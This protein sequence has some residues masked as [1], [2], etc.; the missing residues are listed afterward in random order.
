MLWL[1]AE[2]VGVR[3]GGFDL[4]SLV[5]GNLTE[6]YG[7][8]KEEAARFVT[9][10]Q[11]DGSVRF[12]PEGQEELVY[13]L[14]VDEKGWVAGTSPYET[15]YMLTTDEKTV[16]GILRTAAEQRLLAPWDEDH[17]QALITLLRTAGIQPG[18]ETY[19]ARDA[20]GALH[21]MLEGMFGPDIR[22]TDT[23][24]G[25]FQEQLAEFQL[26]YAP[27]PF[28]VP[29][30]R[31]ITYPE[32]NTVSVTTLTLFDGE[33][34]EEFRELFSDPRLIGWSCL[35]GAV[36]EHDWS[37][38][39]GLVTLP[40]GLGL[41]AMEKDGTRTLFQLE[42]DSGV[43]KLFPLGENALR[44]KGDFRVT[45]CC[46][47]ETFAVDYLLE[48]GGIE[49]FCLSPE[50][51]DPNHYCEIQGFEHVGPASDGAWWIK[52]MAGQYATW[53]D[54]KTA[55]LWDMNYPM[56]LGLLPA[57]EFPGTEKPNPSSVMPEGW[58][59]VSGANLR[60]QASSHSRSCGVLPA[61]TIIPVLEVLPG[62]GHSW[63]KTRIG[64]L[65]GYVSALYTQ[66]ENNAV[67]LIGPQL[68]AK[69]GRD[70]TLKKDTGWMGTGWF[71]ESAG[72]FPK[73]TKMHVFFETGDWLYV[74]VPRV[75]L[76]WLP[77]FEGTFGYVRKNDVITAGTEAVLDWI[78]DGR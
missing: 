22:W 64:F 19:F 45:W 73:G 65:E 74:S 8:T 25:I 42:E 17:R 61:G 52:G 29:G 33:I 13:T 76:T 7:Y 5:R 11:A 23:V 62:S 3:A 14:Y 16:R 46:R 58:T 18:N 50:T 38:V 54:E 40:G 35:S 63:V 9:E 71:A 75:A 48:D 12:W 44:Q 43:W 57:S 31:R 37:A 28:H 51:G 41:A 20:G 27:E 70:I 59:A 21:G 36:A 39:Q 4:K 69:A 55:S 15:G 56:T 77:D 68:L 47:R 78:T 1:I 67:G 2:T 6:V 10:S 30:V 66:V 32:R 53:K 49:T 60:T 34:P 24:R 72:T 26:N